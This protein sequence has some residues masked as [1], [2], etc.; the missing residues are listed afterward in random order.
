MKNDLPVK[1]LEYIIA[2]TPVGD[3]SMILDRKIVITSGFDKP[4]KLKEKLIFEFKS[5]ELN[6]AANDYGYNQ[7]ISEYFNGQ[8]NALDEIPIRQSG[9]K[10]HEMIWKLLRKTKPGETITY[11]ELA[12]K[13]DNPLA[14]RAAGTACGKNK[15]CLIVP[16][17]RIVK[18][19][20]SLGNYFYGERI[21][22]YLLDHESSQK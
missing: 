4:Q 12:R 20:G 14:I 5:I 3:F 11:K 1:K 18:S 7:L 17:H 6:K 22:K 8:L 13:T 15:I 21:K 2:N 19:D 10:F 9:G 16:C